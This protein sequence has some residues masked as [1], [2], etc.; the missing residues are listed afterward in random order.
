MN[1]PS[2]LTSSWCRN[3]SVARW[4]RGPATSIPALLTS[5]S[6]FSAC[7]IWLTLAASASTAGSSVT[8]NRSGTNISPNSRCKRLASFV[9]RT[10][11]N[12]RNPRLTRTLAAASP[13]PVE[14]PVITTCFMDCRLARSYAENG[15]ASIRR[16][17]VY[18]PGVGDSQGFPRLNSPGGSSTNAV[19]SGYSLKSLWI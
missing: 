12:T 14:T 19:A 7:N 8:S 16:S 6:S 11:P 1:G 18:I 9:L 2:R 13:I 15:S 3:C 10:L 5:P 4:A 17:Q